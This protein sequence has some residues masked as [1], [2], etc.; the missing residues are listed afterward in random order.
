[1]DPVAGACAVA[2]MALDMIESTHHF[3]TSAGQALQI[4]VGIHSGPVVAA[5]IGLK[6]PHYCLFGDTVNTAS[7]LESNSE[8]MRICLSTDTVQLLQVRRS[9]PSLESMMNLILWIKRLRKLG[10]FA[11]CESGLWRPFVWAP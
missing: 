9:R 4:R 8:A 2:D 7:R 10:R 5:V 3:L 1:M 11:A 6:M